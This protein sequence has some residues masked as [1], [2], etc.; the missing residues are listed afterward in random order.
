MIFTFILTFFLISCGQTN[1]KSTAE[2]VEALEV[3]VDTSLIAIMKV[4]NSTSYVYP[5]LRDFNYPELT[6]NDLEKIEKTLLD[7]TKDY[8]IE[9]EKQ[10]EEITAKYPDFKFDK[11][12][13]II[14]L[15][16]YKRQYYATTN[17]NGEKEVWINC[18]CNVLVG[19]WR[20]ELIIVHDGGNCFFN[21]KVNL[22]TEKFYDVMVNGH[23]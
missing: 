5:F 15:S 21:L 4:D 11:N 22:D 10:Y 20:K 18:F 8:N 13:F 2:N 19:D 16:R 23:A 17:E 9:Q 7:F 1:K 12:H 3:M 6:T 14:D